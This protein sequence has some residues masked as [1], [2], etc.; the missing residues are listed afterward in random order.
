MSLYT[1][2]GGQV[3]LLPPPDGYI[4]DFENPQ[5]QYVAALYWA[6]GVLSFIAVFCLFQRLYTNVVVEKKFLVED[7][8]LFI[9]W[10]CPLNKRAQRSILTLAVIRH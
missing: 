1:H 9:G 5:R 4:S 3:T 2:P 6:S 8:F 10:V 7:A